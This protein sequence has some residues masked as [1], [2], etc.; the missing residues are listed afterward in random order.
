MVLFVILTNVLV[1]FIQTGATDTTGLSGCSTNDN[2]T[3]CESVGRGSFFSSLGDVTVSGLDGAPLIFNAL[4]VTVLGGL[5]IIGLVIF[6][7][8]LIPTVPG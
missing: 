1:A 7:V 3:S 6:V 2:V 4:Y 5:L 8:G